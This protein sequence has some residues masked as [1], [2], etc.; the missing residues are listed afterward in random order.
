VEL[1]DQ[2]LKTEKPYIAIK[3]TAGAGKSTLAINLIKEYLRQDKKILYL[4]FNKANKEE[5]ISKLLV[6]GIA[7]EHS[8]SIIKT[9]DGLI[10]KL[11][12]VDYLNWNYNKQ[13]NINKRFKSEEF[14]HLLN[15]NDKRKWVTNAN[16]YF[17]SLF[18]DKY[19]KSLTLDRTTLLSETKEELIEHFEDYQKNVID[20]DEVIRVSGL[21]VNKLINEQK[22]VQPTMSLAKKMLYVILKNNYMPN[23]TK[24][25]YII[26]DEAQDTNL[27]T[28]EILKLLNVKQRIFMGQSEQAIYSFLGNIDVFKNLKEDNL[29][30]KNIFM[31]NSYRLPPKV[32]EEAKFFATNY[33]NTS[34]NTTGVNE[35]IVESKYTTYI[36]R[37]NITILETIM[38]NPDKVYRLFKEADY[39]TK[40]LIDTYNFLIEPHRRKPHDEYA[41]FKDFHEEYLEE[42]YNNYPFI[43]WAKEKKYP[44]AKFLNDLDKL[45]GIE[46]VKKLKNRIIEMKKLETPEDDILINA[47]TSKGMTVYDVVINTDFYYALK[48]SCKL[49]TD[50]EINIVDPLTLTGTRKAEWNLFYVAMTRTTTKNTGLDIIWTLDKKALLTQFKQ[51]IVSKKPV[52]IIL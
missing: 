12:I 37:K 6:K 24:Y 39:F 15:L 44:V 29:D 35:E 41:I 49:E 10:Y 25:D 8:N 26:I 16:A 34:N 47:F 18:L 38:I 36:S 14:K 23:L 33:L 20:F 11:I 42:N 21:Y 45:K 5:M 30:V 31:E 28:Y 17:I 4:V 48:D 32:G 40:P 50:T 22:I 3:A 51:D 43:E 46:G 9:I 27:L 7:K 2:V 52:H 13:F 1:I 19:T